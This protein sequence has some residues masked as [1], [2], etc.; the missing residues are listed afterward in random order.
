VRGPDVP[1]PRGGGAGSRDFD[2]SDVRSG[3][4]SRMTPSDPAAA[5]RAAPDAAHP[6]RGSV[7]NPTTQAGASEALDLYPGAAGRQAGPSAQPLPDQEIDWSDDEACWLPGTRPAAGNL[8]LAT[9]FANYSASL[10]AAEAS[11]P[12]V[13]APGGV[14]ADPQLYQNDVESRVKRARKEAYEH[15]TRLAGDL[16]KTSP[17][18]WAAFD[19][20]AQ[21][22]EHEQWIAQAGLLATDADLPSMSDMADEFERGIWAEHFK[23]QRARAVTTAMTT[24]YPNIGDATGDRFKALGIAKDA[25]LKLTGIEWF[26]NGHLFEDYDDDDAR[27]TMAWSHRYKPKQ[28]GR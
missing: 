16:E 8:D 10:A 17:E 21:R 27:A 9:M 25:G 2:V 5:G 19:A 15:F 3:P 1:L 14:N 6:Q 28:F 7:W 20:A 18:A 12:V 26:E 4:Q 23:R 22:R 11:R 24:V 13:F